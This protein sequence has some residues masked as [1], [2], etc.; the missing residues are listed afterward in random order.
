MYGREVSSLLKH[1]LPFIVENHLKEKLKDHD[2]TTYPEKSQ[3]F[4]GIKEGFAE[5]NKEVCTILSD[6]RFR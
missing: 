2:M 6:V 1:R 5:A 4:L 3:V